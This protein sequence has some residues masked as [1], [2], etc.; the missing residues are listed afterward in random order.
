M[1]E[2]L[3]VGEVSVK[4]PFQSILFGRQGESCNLT[5]MN[6]GGGDDYTGAELFQDHKDDA[7]PSWQDRGKENGNGGA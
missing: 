5:Y 7:E 6:K 1:S 4:R 3:S 2:E